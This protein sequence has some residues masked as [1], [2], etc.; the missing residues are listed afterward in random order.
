[1][2]PRKYIFVA[3]TLVFFLISFVNLRYNHS[4]F[5]PLSL[6]VSLRHEPPTDSPVDHWTWH[7][8][9]RF[10]PQ[11]AASPDATEK[12]PC[13]A[14]PTPLL[15]RVQVVLKIGS[16]EPPDRLDAQISTVS[17]CISNLIIF[18][19]REQKL[20]PHPAYDI[21]AD[22][23]PSYMANNSDF[24]VYHGA[25]IQ[26]ADK[27]APGWRLDRY[28]FL[29]MVERA[30]QMNPA[31]DWFVFLEADTYIVWDNLFRLLEHF[32]PNTPLYMGSPAPG[33]RLP[34]G[35]TTWFAYGGTGTVLSSAAVK[36]VVTR[37]VG[38]YGEFSGPSLTEKYEGDVKSDCCGDSVLGWA[39]YRAGI[40]L[41]GLWP[42]FNP[43][44]FHSIPFADAYWCQPIISAHRSSPEEMRAFSKWEAQRG[45]SVC[46]LPPFLSCHTNQYLQEPLLYRDIFHHLNLGTITNHSDW[47]NANFHGF[48]PDPS[49]FAHTSF[50]ACAAACHDHPECFQFTYDS[51]GFC[52]FVRSIRLGLEH[53][54][55]A[56][57]VHLSSGW[58]VGKINDWAR[59]RV[60]ETPIWVKPSITRIF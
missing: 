26:G 56:N 47:D 39:L 40:K 15:S 18:S 13:A 54:D 41:S 45:Y 21:L 52:N 30:Y 46:V 53:V 38:Q 16:S 6:Q 49:S 42:L 35:E 57:K 9:S 58:D 33:R 29:P 37:D 12:D 32:D 51:S 17:R 27:A 55:P 4:E 48:R 19:D 3:V 8:T 34:N 59:D 1:M 25:P 14:F 10:R 43:H 31:A 50:D 2:P 44:P 11:L 24:D 23:P 22:L 28:K 36:K 20:G 60:C 7:T 5:L